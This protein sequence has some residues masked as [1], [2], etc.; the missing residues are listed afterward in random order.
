MIDLAAAGINAN[1]HGRAEQ[2]VPCP[3]CAKGGRDDAL[4]INIET[5]A[6]HCFRCGWKGRAGAA[7]V[8]PIVRFDDPSIAER[9]RERLRRAWKETLPL[10]HA[11]ARAVRTYLESRALGEILAT[12][13]RVLRAHRALPYWDGLTNLGTYPCMVALFHGA[14]GQ[15][16]TLHVT[17]LGEGMACAAEERA[18]RTRRKFRCRFEGATPG[19]AIQQYEP[20]AGI[21]GSH[22]RI[23]SALSMHLLQKLPTWSSYCADNLAAAQ[24]PKGLRELHIGVDIDESGK[25]AEVAQSL[26]AR[27][28]RFSP[29]TKVYIVTP[30]V[31][32]D[33]D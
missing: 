2:R 6:F 12:P 7:E 23:E 4:G 25:G 22:V 5:G 21:S 33:G 16:V 29:R 24:L 27:V 3:Q 30:E 8:K 14:S 26:T 31:D 1:P 20:R 15:P 18:Y 11:N 32:G 17:Y 19:G 13:P 10:N 9:K 28:R